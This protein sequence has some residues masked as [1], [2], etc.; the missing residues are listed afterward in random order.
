MFCI[1]WAGEHA[2]WDAFAVMLRCS[3]ELPQV[4]PAA[5]RTWGSLGSVRMLVIGRPP[6][7]CGLAVGMV[8]V[9]GAC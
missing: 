4:S 1:L 9:S 2:A 8:T 6:G 5:K 3:V 7:A